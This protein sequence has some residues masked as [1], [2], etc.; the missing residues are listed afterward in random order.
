MAACFAAITFEAAI[1]ILHNLE[2]EIAMFHANNGHL[3]CELEPEIK[4]SRINNQFVEAGFSQ[5]K[6]YMRESDD[7]KT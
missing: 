4:V 3:S 7:R 5:M 1:T 2:E 6:K